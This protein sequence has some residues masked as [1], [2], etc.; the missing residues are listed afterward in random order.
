MFQDT[1]KAVPT[2]K[3]ADRARLLADASYAFVKP[4]LRDLHTSLDRR[5]VANL[6]QLIF[7]ILRHRHTTARLLLSE[8]G[9]HL[10]SPAQAPAGTKRLSRLLHS[11]RWTSEMAIRFD[12]SE[13]AFASLCVRD[14]EACGKLWSITALAYAFLLSLLAP[15][16]QHVC[17]WL[18]R[19]WCHRT[20]KWSRE[21]SAPLDRVRSTLSRL[22]L[23][24]PPYRLVTL[25]S[26]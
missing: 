6:L 13:L 14:W 19:N 18:L 11:E 24:H 22:W 3:S 2:Q 10:L 9:G 21:V 17:E 20:G 15:L 12:K 1:P 7:V 16:F 26:G 4:L 8:L 25:D 23:A 5:V